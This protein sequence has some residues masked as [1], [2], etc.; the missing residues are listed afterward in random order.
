[1][2][3]EGTPSSISAGPQAD[4]SS[5]LQRAHEITAR[6]LESIPGK[7]QRRGCSKHLPRVGGAA[8]LVFGF[9]LALLVD[10]LHQLVGERERAVR[11]LAIGLERELRSGPQWPE[12]RRVRA[13]LHVG[14][15][16]ER[17]R[18]RSYVSLQATRNTV[19][20]RWRWEYLGSLDD[21]SLGLAVGC[22]SAGSAFLDLTRVSS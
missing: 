10:G 9:D 16:T 7:G 11:R 17:K 2:E 6:R 22:P 1:M 13:Y 12:M 19:G 8:G 21:F 4:G 20:R 5:T 18:D 14:K 3:P 15:P